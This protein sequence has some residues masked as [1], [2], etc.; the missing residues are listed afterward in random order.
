MVLCEC[1]TIYATS[2]LTGILAIFYSL[3]TINHAAMNYLECILFCYLSLSLESI[4]QEV[5]GKRV[6]ES[7]ILIHIVKFT[8][9]GV[10]SIAV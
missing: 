10:V 4:S 7:A 2:L 3:V 8:S 1:P 9:V 5:S 6:Y